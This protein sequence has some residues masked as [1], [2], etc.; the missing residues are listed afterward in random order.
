MWK[1]LK[2]Y[3]IVEEDEPKKTA[4]A[5]A[6]KST[7]PSAAN[8]PIN[9]AATPEAAPIPSATV[10]PGSVNDKSVKVL[11]E[12][13]ENANLPGFDYLEYK[14]A[15]QNLKKMNFTDEVRFQTAYAAAQSMGVTPQQLEESAS[16][17]LGVLKKEEEKFNQALS[18]QR[19]SQVGSKEERV[20]QL[21]AS[22]QQQEARIKEME[23]QIK[24]AKAEQQKL[25]DTI[26]RSTAKLSQ[27]QADFQATL[28]VITKGIETDRSNIRT[29]LK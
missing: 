11:M 29:F 5:P 18:T 22:I 19:S 1:N 10:N 26:T 12:A 25:K 3:F 9:P 14:K 7:K 8:T 24:K 6:A 13:M 28:A 23:A 2:G 20:K 15:L 17:Y 27:T 4:K 16:H 21:T